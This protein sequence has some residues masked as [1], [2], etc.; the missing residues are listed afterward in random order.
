M[1]KT[2]FSLLAF[3]LAAPLFAQ[4]DSLKVTM[5]SGNLREAMANRQVVR[6]VHDYTLGN[7]IITPKILIKDGAKSRSFPVL[8][9]GTGLLEDDH[10]ALAVLLYH[11]FDWHLQS[12]DQQLSRA[13]EDLIKRADQL[14]PGITETLPNDST[15]WRRLFVCA[16]EYTAILELLG[17]TEL[18]RIMEWRTTESPIKSVYAL[19]QPYYDQ[20]M[21]QVVRFR[22]DLPRR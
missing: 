7:W 16:F 9:M 12:R 17:E 3:L 11:E 2:V 1:R 21:N 4:Q 14:I 22:L 18:N 13:I 8:T 5:Q 15:N 19:V 6:V 20:I 10:K